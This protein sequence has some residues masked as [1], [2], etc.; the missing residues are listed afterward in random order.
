MRP[1][2]L[3]TL[4]AA[5]L[6]GAAAWGGAPQR[7]VS[8]NVCTDQLAFLLAAPGQLI[9][10]SP[11]AHDPRTSAL[12]AEMADLPRN[13]GSAEAVVLR[14]PDL[15]LAGSW[16]TRATVQLLDR[17][18]YRVETFAPVTSLDTARANMLRMGELLGR[19]AEAR[20]MVADFD[21][22]RAALTAPA[23]RRPRAV[24]YMPYG[25]T[26][27][28][29]SLTGDLLNAAGLDNLAPPS[30]HLSMEE[31]VLSDPDLILVGRPYAGH[32]RATEYASHPALQATGALR[33]V[34]DG[35]SWTCETPKLLEA[36]ATLRAIRDEVTE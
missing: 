33:E 4:A 36:L 8:L 14:R 24:Y 20:A 21:T 16:T 3:I 19:E 6:A 13:D 7:V 31:L 28:A 32:A 26:A 12:A 11:L 17:L 5:L 23:G 35:T 10:V 15:V 29:D 30:G 9:S 1:S 2:R 27:G 34:A 25:T 22:R 18:G